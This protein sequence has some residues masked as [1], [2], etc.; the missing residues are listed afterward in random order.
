ME[1]KTTAN[2]IFM[3]KGVSSVIHSFAL[4][5][6]PSLVDSWEVLNPLSS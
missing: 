5:P 6:S 3:I 1:I 4:Y 2:I